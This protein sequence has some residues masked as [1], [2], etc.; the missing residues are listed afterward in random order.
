MDTIDMIKLKAFAP[1]V[2]AGQAP[3]RGFPFDL[4]H[5]VLYYDLKPA[6]LEAFVNNVKPVMA[7]VLSRCRFFN[8]PLEAGDAAETKAARVNRFNRGDDGPNTNLGQWGDDLLIL[9]CVKLEGSAKPGV[10]EWVVFWYSLPEPGLVPDVGGSTIARFKT[11]D[12]APVV[13]SHFTSW[14]HTR[15]PL[16]ERVVGDPSWLDVRN[17]MGRLRFGALNHR[18]S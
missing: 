3:G 13:L 15:S 18:S 6:D 9:S 8:D 4:E 16:M 2:K 11:G 1:Y 17:F 12:P 5:R 14:A 10:T 7:C